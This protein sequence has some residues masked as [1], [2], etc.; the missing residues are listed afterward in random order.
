M[1]TIKFRCLKKIGMD[2]FLVDLGSLDVIMA[3]P[4]DLFLLVSAYDTGLWSA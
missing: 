2:K 4:D 3:L 1:K